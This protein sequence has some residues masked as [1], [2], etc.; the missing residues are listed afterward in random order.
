VTETLLAIQGIGVAGGFGLGKE[1]LIDA[2]RQ[3]GRPNGTVSILTPAGP[4]C[5]PA[6]QVD[7][8]PVRRYVSG[9]AWRRMNRYAKLALLGAS[10][11]LEDAGWDRS[12]RAHDLGL[13]V[14]SGY[15]AS[16]STFDFLDTM[17]EDGGRCPSP[18]QFSNSVHSSAVSHLSIVLQ[19]G[20]P[21]LTVSQFE[22]S[23]VS[24]LLTAREWLREGRV[25][26][27][28]FG[29]VDEI[30]P[31]LNYGYDRFF[32]EAASG[33]MEPFA[34]NRQT[35]V[36]GEG[37]AFLLLTRREGAASYGELEAVDWVRAEEVVADPDRG[38]VLGADGQTCSA[39]TYRRLASEH[40]A[41]VVYSP[42][43][44]S[45]PGGQAFDLAAAALAARGGMG[46]QRVVS[47]KC[48]AY[49]NCGVIACEFQGPSY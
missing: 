42:V 23:P 37:A 30:C 31:V 41:P 7:E 1:S 33:P 19:A 25:Q 4:R 48:D 34:W 40:P 38:L 29:A 32:G 35:A 49:E 46:P 12:M 21:C 16:Q 43:Y 24:A 36:L 27:V 47:V 2:L 14:A 10:Q 9:G 22:M 26:G 28:L 8:S 18:T 20:G 39:R 3:G 13:V 45:L 44:G 5:L 15:G 17:I 6:Y 11:A